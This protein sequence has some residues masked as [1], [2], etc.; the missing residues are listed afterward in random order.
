MVPTLRV[1][2]HGG[3]RGRLVVGV[4]LV[5]NQRQNRLLL[6]LLCFCLMLVDEIL[7]S[8]DV[9]ALHPGRIGNLLNL[10]ELLGVELV[11]R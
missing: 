9:V 2:V 3:D 11:V 6:V 7:L 4:R 5:G 1:V 10:L 8:R